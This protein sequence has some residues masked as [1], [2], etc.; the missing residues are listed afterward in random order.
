MSKTGVYLETLG[1]PELKAAFERL[2]M[3][4]TKETGRALYQEGEKIMGTS[5][6]FFV[7]VDRG[8]LRASG[9]VQPPQYEG[10]G[11]VV[12]IGYGGPAVAYAVVQHEKLYYKHKVGQAKYLERP[13]LQEAV[14]MDK[15]IAARL[16]KRLAKI[17]SR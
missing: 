7:P 9:H 1:V 3:D 6:Q 14:V 10:G 11:V 16:Q 5:K 8:V 12:V 4:F 13:A 17:A 15:R 2:E